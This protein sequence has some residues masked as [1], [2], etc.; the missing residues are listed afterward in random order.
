MEAEAG[1][2]DELSKDLYK[3]VCD[4]HRFYGDMRFKQLSL[5]GVVTALLV[6]AI[7]SKEAARAAI[8]VSAI[9]VMAVVS[10]S[11][12]WIMEVRSSSYGYRCQKRRDQ[13]EI[14]R[15]SASG[16]SFPPVEFHWTLVNATN[17]VLLLYVCSYLFW[18]WQWWVAVHHEAPIRGL[19]LVLGFGILIAFSAREYWERW[20]EHRSHWRW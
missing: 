6:N 2:V 20:C 4:E 15:Q 13:F 18:L 7:N 12:L 17:T 16:A 11:V 8:S 3:Q 1:R 5:Y 19:L 9:C 10:T 14:S